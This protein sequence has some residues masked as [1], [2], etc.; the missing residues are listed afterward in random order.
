MYS[1]FKS[2]L[3]GAIPLG[4]DATE[5]LLGFAVFLLTLLV[6]RRPMSS[7]WAA[8]PT[9]ICAL[10]IALLD[11]IALGQGVSGALFDALLFSSVAVIMTLIYRM[12][13]AK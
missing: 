10:V 3:W 8:L 7:W 5:L 4:G 12:G 1:T 13:W 6:F 11:V 9:V 2:T